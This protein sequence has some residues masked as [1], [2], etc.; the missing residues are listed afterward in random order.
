M[1]WLILGALGW[2]P[3]WYSCSDRF[4]NIDIARARLGP[5]H[6]WC[7]FLW[8]VI[9][10]TLGPHFHLPGS[11]WVMW[12]Y[13]VLWERSKIGVSNWGISWSSFPEW[14]TWLESVPCWSGWYS[15][16]YGSLTWSFIETQ[17]S[18]AQPKE[19][20]VAWLHM[21]WLHTDR[22]GVPGGRWTLD[23]IFTC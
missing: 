9:W 5:I 15:H 4:K 22:W 18:Y 16:A 21:A 14:T 10:W 23:A 13:R 8:K 12:T 19:S 7:T 3:S 17:L 1:P 20:H 2:L 11:P 6:I